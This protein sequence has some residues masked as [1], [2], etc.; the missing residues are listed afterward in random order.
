MTCEGD[1]FCST[2]LYTGVVIGS[3]SGGMHVKT[4]CV[5]LPVN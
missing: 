5:V 3:L 2:F 4:I 1:D